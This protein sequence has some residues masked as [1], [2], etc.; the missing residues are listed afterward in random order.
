MLVA[1]PA[2]L[3]LLMELIPAGWTQRPKLWAALALI[4]IP[5][6][7]AVDINEITASVELILRMWPRGY[8]QLLLRYFS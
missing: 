1:A 8:F 7:M 5:I 6:A 2:A 4:W 3:L